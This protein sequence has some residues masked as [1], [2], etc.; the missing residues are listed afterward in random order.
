MKLLVLGNCQARP[1]A[2]I[3]AHAEA[4]QVLPPIILHL[5]KDTDLELHEKLFHEADLIVAQATSESFKPTHLQSSSIKERFGD[6]VTIWP[7]IFF[8]G[9]TPRLRYVTHRKQGRIFGPL[10]AYHDLEILSDWFAAKSDVDFNYPLLETEKIAARSL[11]ELE[12]KEAAC[13][14]AISDVIA[15]SYR[16]HALFF[17]FN[18][19][20]QWLLELTARRILERNGFKL[21]Q[22][23]PPKDEPLGRI[24][25]PNIFSSNEPC[26]DQFQGISTSEETLNRRKAFSSDTLRL[27]FFEYYD[28]ISEDLSNI[29]E[30]SF[31][32]PY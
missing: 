30:L 9:Q 27:N 29:E 13:D 5:S 21:P 1:L 16:S 7:N 24:R 3:L 4:F 15:E 31:T 6:R 10:D 8:L 18:H 26:L 32:P 2:S 14:V 19:P 20:T 22:V 11:A 28:T 12:S 25:P 23:P 17:T